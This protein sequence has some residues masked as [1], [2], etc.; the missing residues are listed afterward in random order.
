MRH[1]EYV[2]NL[3]KFAFRANP[4]LYL[5]ILLSVFSVFLEILAV[6]SLMPLFAMASGS[7]HPNAGVI[8][9]MLG[10]MGWEVTTA[11][12]LWGFI[13]IFIVRIL[14]QIL[15]Q[16]LST[17]LGRKVLAQMAS[18]A[19]HQIMKVVS[20]K[21]ISE[22]S[23][24]YFISLAGDEAFRASVLVISL[25]QFVSISCLAVLY[26]LAIFQYSH[27]AAGLVAL[28][29]LCSALALTK[30]FKTSHFLGGRQIEESRRASS[31]FLD[32]LNNMKAVRAFS[33]EDY[34]VGMYRGF[35][36][37]YAKTLFLVDQ[38][39]LLARLL[40]VLILLGILG[41]WLAIHN[42]PIESG[43][44]LFVATIGI[45]IMRLFPVVGQAV[46]LLLRIISDAKAGRDVTKIISGGE[47]PEALLASLNGPV[48]TI[49]FEDVCFSY[50]EKSLELVLDKVH[51]RFEKGNSYALVGRSG[52]GKSTVIDILLKF[53]SASDGMVAI[54]GMDINQ[55]SASDVRQRILLVS[56][57]AAIFD[58]TVRN[59]ICMGID[60][61]L[62]QVQKACEAA[63]I[64]DVIAAMSDG[65]ETRLQYQGKNLSGGQ[66][67]RVAIARALLRT[68]DG[69]IFDE[70][71]SALDKA[72]QAVI[73]NGIL[74]NY[75]DKIVIFVTHDPDIMRCVDHVIDVGAA[76][77]NE[78]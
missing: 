42:A 72:T 14:T 77:L 6:S 16:S 24:G 45:Y 3:F 41:G 12:L 68:P 29:F 15:G 46:T 25:T 27:F 70:S 63:Q 4:M 38:M 49:T 9:K 2:V 66:R 44:L 78:A 57:D 52:V 60:A 53:Y 36:F 51:L 50:S 28:F 13:V 43:S 23:I 35:M 48:S 10:F 58:D 5:S 47:H 62:E 40:P 74:R 1:L 34:V 67:Q 61:S 73:V 21:D 75:A 7:L 19:F 65:Y 59:N 33:A 11:A 71:T 54:N 20:V 55:I 18:R 69:L 17:Y 26:Y 8:G 64:H 30:V 56:Q 37:Q 32:S 22:K 31:I 39:A 76:R